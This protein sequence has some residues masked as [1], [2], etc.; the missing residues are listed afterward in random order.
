MFDVVELFYDVDVLDA[1][2]VTRCAKYRS[3]KVESGKERQMSFRC[4]CWIET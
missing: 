4:Y 3:E 1:T 2:I